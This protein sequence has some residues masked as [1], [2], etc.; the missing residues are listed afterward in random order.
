MMSPVT[1][2]KPHASAFPF[3]PSRLH[4]DANIWAQSPGDRQCV[5]DRVAVHHDDFVNARWQSV[6][7]VREVEGFVQCRNDY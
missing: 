4:H 6:Q 1:A 5:I 3:S 2:A 7:N